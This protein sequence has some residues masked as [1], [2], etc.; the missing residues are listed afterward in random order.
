M[1]ILP[2]GE[3]SD[4]ERFADE[5]EG[6][7][8]P[9]EFVTSDREYQSDSEDRGVDPDYVP[10]D[11][12]GPDDNVPP[13]AAN[14]EVAEDVRSLVAN[15]APGNLLSD[16]TIQAESDAHQLRLLVEVHNNAG[17]QVELPEDTEPT[18]LSDIQPR[19][20]NQPSASFG[21][22][23]E[24]KGAKFSPPPDELQEPIEYFYKFFGKDL[25]D[26]IALQTMMYAHQNNNESFRV[27]AEEIE[28]FL[29]VHLE[30][31]TCKMPRIRRYWSPRTRYS[32]VADC[33]SY[34]KFADLQ[35]YL[36]FNDNTKMKKK[37][38][39]GYDPLF[40][41]RPILDH[42]RK[43]CLKTEPEEHSSV[44]EVMV[45]FKGRLEIK[46]YIKNKPTKW[47]IKIFSIAGASGLTY[48]FLVYIG[49]GTVDNNRGIGIGGEV[50]LKL[51]DFLPKDKNYKVTFDNWFCGLP[52]LSE[53]KKIGIL[54]TGTIRANRTMKCPLPD[55]KAMKQMA[56]GSYVAR[57]DQKNDI[58]VVK[59]LDTKCVT[60]AS[61]FL[62]AEPLDDCKRWDKSKKQHV[63]V[64][65]PHV[66]S[67]YN[68]SMGGV[69]LS[70]MI[71]ALYK[72][73][74]R[75]PR[76][77]MRLFYF[78]VDLSITNAWLLYRRHAK[79]KGVEPEH[80]SLGFRDS[81]A[82]SLTKAG[83]PV[84]PVSKKRG[85]PSTDPSSQPPSPSTSQQSKRPQQCAPGK[86]VRV[87]GFEHYPIWV[88]GA[89]T[90]CKR[91]KCG[92]QSFVQCAKC[93]VSLC[94]NAKRNC[95]TAFHNFT[96]N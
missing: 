1:L 71:N 54:A 2:D 17:L 85:R 81:V 94:L 3:I 8:D 10:S 4:D 83:K 28:V 23:V 12:D 86:S 42:V 45:P 91:E 48:D 88:T 22:N 69:D 33:I 65:R 9:D 37:S 87:D 35:K 38:E 78:L 55:D 53:L 46:Q 21:A 68:L 39:Q 61:S 43:N 5:S 49:K 25:F 50:V 6:E 40:K 92:Y 30:M 29:G 18:D 57:Y 59:W 84:T 70:D 80:D 67:E 34:K 96:A 56:R 74:I 63:T 31:S 27:S 75:S 62:K 89:R 66:I 73:D 15:P 44:D 52:L 36:H 32:P 19:W 64:A 79:Q 26:H 13:V 11:D 20:R 47:G 82:E 95:F 41:V 58:C 7:P 76:W 77:Y 24:F 90:W 72:Q 14:V 60:V 51:V 16:E 93:K